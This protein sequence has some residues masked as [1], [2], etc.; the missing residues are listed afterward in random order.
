MMSKLTIDKRG[1]VMLN[2]EAFL[3]SGVSLATGYCAGR[4][5]GENTAEMVKRWNAYDG[6]VEALERLIN[7]KT[8]EEDEDQP[9]WHGEGLPPVGVECEAYD[10]TIGDWVLGMTTSAGYKALLFNSENKDGL[11]KEFWATKFRPTQKKKIDMSKFYGS[12][13]LLT[14]GGNDYKP[15]SVLMDEDLENYRPLCGHWN[16]W[17]GGEMPEFLEGFNYRI[18]S[19]HSITGMIKEFESDSKIPWRQVCAIK[20]TDLKEGWEF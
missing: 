13:F 20:I 2:G 12:E 19:Y 16:H 15:E 3:L 1:N 9:Q 8:N 5:D 17:T 7:S 14:D 6:L 18:K 10:I 11:L 4:P